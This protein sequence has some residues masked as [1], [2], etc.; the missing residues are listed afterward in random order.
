MLHSLF[1]G[2]IHVQIVTSDDTLKGEWII[3]NVTTTFMV[4]IAANF[5][6]VIPPDTFYTWHVVP[7]TNSLKPTTVEGNSCLSYSFP[8]NGRYDLLVVGN[9]SAGSFS[10]QL[11][12]RAECK[13]LIACMQLM[14]RSIIIVNCEFRL[15]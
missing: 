13:W 9:H 2:A 10:A 6:E 4:D 15:H 7:A 5:S 8:L 11:L 3:A 12:L 14:L 1:T